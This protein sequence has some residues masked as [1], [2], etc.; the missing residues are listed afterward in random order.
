MGILKLFDLIKLRI[1]MVM[2]KA[3]N[4]LLPGNLAAT[5]LQCK[6]YH[7]AYS[8][9]FSIQ[10]FNSFNSLIPQIHIYRSI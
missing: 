10:F 4:E 9:F 1:S 5:I 8:F 7:V 2:F 3:N 6:I